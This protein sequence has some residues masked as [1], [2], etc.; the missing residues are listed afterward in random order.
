MDLAIKVLITVFPPR[1][2]PYIV[3]S[4]DD[5]I[6][7]PVVVGRTVGGDYRLARTLMADSSAY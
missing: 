7:L 4:S 6:H 3:N 2:F 5:S 1:C